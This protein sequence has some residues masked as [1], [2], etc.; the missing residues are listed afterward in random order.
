MDSATCTTQLTEATTAAGRAPR[1]A[2]SCVPASGSWLVA[3]AISSI[4][5][6]PTATKYFHRQMNAPAARGGP[7]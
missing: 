7:L 6:V 2:W 3:P 1:A 5:V 4:A